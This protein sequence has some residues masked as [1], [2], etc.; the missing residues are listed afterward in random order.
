MK[1]KKTKI[2]II[3][4]GHVG[5]HILYTLALQ[6]LGDIFILADLE[7]N[8]RKVISERQDILDSLIYLPHH[9]EI[10]AGS[11]EDMGDCDV[12]INCCGRISILQTASTRV[13][14]LE[15]NYSAVHSYAGRL[16]KAGFSGVLINI[17][18]PCDIITGELADILEL[19]RGKVFGTGT[20]LDT[21]RLRAL[22][23]ERI[24]LNA[25]SVSAYMLGEHGNAQFTPWSCVFV[26]GK[27]LTEW[28]KTDKRFAFDLQEAETAAAQGGWI[29]YSGKFCTEYAI[30]LTGARAVHAVLYDEQVILPVSAP[31]EGEYGERN[32]FVGVPARIGAGGVE[33]VIELPL[34]EDEKRKFHVCCEEIRHNKVTFKSRYGIKK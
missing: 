26:G 6:G 20:G 25:G 15:F 7:D 22:L 2:G 21:A 18:N 31:L 19:P 4:T 33:E 3:G 23:S 17:S 16:K 30:A 11:Y 27:N 10:L 32:I 13:A 12:I 8:R 14:E 5:A 28:A 9:V 1:M 34:T 29:T 24:G